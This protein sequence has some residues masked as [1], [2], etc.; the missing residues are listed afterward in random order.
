MQQ[1]TYKYTK[2]EFQ[3]TVKNI[4]HREIKLKLA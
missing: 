4:I 2:H 1:F 3:Q